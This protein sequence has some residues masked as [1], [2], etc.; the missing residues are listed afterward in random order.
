MKFRTLLFG[1]LLTFA[2]TSRVSAQITTVTYDSI[3]IDSV[4]FVPDTAEVDSIEGYPDFSQARMGGND[5]FPV[6]F[7]VDGLQPAIMDSGATLQVY[8]SRES[9][10]SCAM[11]IVFEAYDF[12]TP[13]IPPTKY[14][15]TIY[16]AEG[17]PENV[18]NMTPILAPA[19][20]Y[21]TMYLSV[22]ASG[23]PG[24]PGADSCF[25]DAIVLVQKGSIS[26]SVAQN[27]GIQQQVLMNYPN[28]FYHTSGTRVQ[29]HT[30]VA[31][32]GMLS[33]TDALGRDVMNVPLGALSA[34]D[35]NVSIALASAGS[36]FVRLI[37]DGVPTGSP[38]EISGE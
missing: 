9:S 10:D 29:V 4:F 11:D 2:A 25:L 23:I 36:Y 14:S 12:T 19:S 32:I 30:P 28:P 37:V 22:G 6:Q 38:L 1:L 18:W 31:G 20:G 35:E 7:W 3:P 26:A 24:Q 27:A 5:A 17:G 8:W 34:G 15:S 33:V 16:M 21:N 13:S